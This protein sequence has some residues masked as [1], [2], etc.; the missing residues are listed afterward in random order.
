MTP[1]TIEV[2]I[3][4]VVLRGFA[5]VDR[6]AVA[7]AIEATLARLLDVGTADW[8][9]AAGA[10]P[11]LD[12]GELALGEGSADEVGAAIARALHSSLGALAGGG[13]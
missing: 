11:H 12:A 3:D 9:G 13:A 8:A 1:A 6:D 2:H 7:A 10:R 4:E 5:P